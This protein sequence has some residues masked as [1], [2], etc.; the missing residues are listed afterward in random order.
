MF[1]DENH[2]LLWALLM[3]DIFRFDKNG[4]LTFIYIWVFEI[5][6]RIREIAYRL[7]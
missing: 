7:T 6:E 5:P 4:K 1:E 3:N 2:V